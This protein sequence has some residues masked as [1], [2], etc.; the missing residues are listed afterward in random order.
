MAEFLTLSKCCTLDVHPLYRD[1]SAFI[2]AVKQNS[3]IFFLWCSPVV[4]G[5]ISVIVIVFKK[6]FKSFALL[7]LKTHRLVLSFL[8]I[9]M[10]KCLCL[11]PIC[12]MYTA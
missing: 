3:N 2:F 5:V 11:A 4:L 7:H 12:F 10:F 1:T 8:R 6:L 9:N